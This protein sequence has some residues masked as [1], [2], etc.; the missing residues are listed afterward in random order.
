MKSKQTKKVSYNHR[1]F[2]SK[3]VLLR[4]KKTVLR[5]KGGATSTGTTQRGFLNR[6]L[7]HKN[8]T[9]RIPKFR[10]NPKPTSF[11]LTSQFNQ[12]GEIGMVNNPMHG[13]NGSVRIDPKTMFLNKVTTIS[14]NEDYLEVNNKET[15][16]L[17]KVKTPNQYETIPP[18]EKSYISQQP[19]N[20]ND[21]Y[22]EVDQLRRPS[23]N[24]LY[25]TIVNVEPNLFTSGIYENPNES[26][27]GSSANNQQRSAENIIRNSKRKDIHNKLQKI[28][29]EIFELIENT[30]KKNSKLDKDYIIRTIETVMKNIDLHENN[31]DVIKSVNSI[32]NQFG[33]VDKYTSAPEI[34]LYKLF[35]IQL[36]KFNDE[37]LEQ[38]NDE[39]FKEFLD[40]ILEVIVYQITKQISIKR[41]FAEFENQRG[42]IIRIYLKNIFRKISQEPSR[43][44]D[45]LEIS[46]EENANNINARI[47]NKNERLRYLLHL[48]IKKE[49]L[50]KKKLRNIYKKYL[51]YDYI[52]QFPNPKQIENCLSIVFK[53]VYIEENKKKTTFQFFLFLLI[54]FIMELFKKKKKGEK[55][56]GQMLPVLIEKYIIFLEELFKI[57]QKNIEIAPKQEN[58]QYVNIKQETE[59]YIKE[60]I[61]RVII[62]SRISNNKDNQIIPPARFSNN[63]TFNNR[64]NKDYQNTCFN[65]RMLKLFVKSQIFKEWLERYFQTD[66]EIKKQFFMDYLEDHKFVCELTLEFFYL[67]LYEMIRDNIMNN[68]KAKS[69]VID[70]ESISLLIDNILEQLS[71]L[72]RT[73]NFDEMI[74][75]FLLSTKIKIKT[76]ALFNNDDL[77]FFYEKVMSFLTEFKNFITQEST[78]LEGINKFN[79]ATKP[80]K[81]KR[82]IMLISQKLTQLYDENKILITAHYKKTL[83]SQLVSPIY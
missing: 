38:K 77:Y 11:N 30:L 83:T 78:V 21:I 20:N 36:E 1:N 23:S 79:T 28:F 31:E 6:I 70:T 63:G 25:N 41:F 13:I 68:I 24:N 29:D 57:Y 19:I 67:K 64:N 65:I 10:R 60:C 76:R 17:S 27:Y 74:A 35:E 61:N 39:Q 40:I 80:K 49:K 72:K 2:K 53:Y 34:Y 37:K 5:M 75:L 8:G 47:Y 66:S 15:T 18:I 58:E 81:F 33:S 4:K 32:I 51:E 9:Y 43:V 7:K 52:I 14:N 26:L 22:E 46:T 45:I 73:N 3:T 54:K 12:T 50:L 44:M 55:D 62:E 71:N 69:N 59:N 42:I 16:P 82:K 56:Y 48:L